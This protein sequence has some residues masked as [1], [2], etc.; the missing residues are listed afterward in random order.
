MKFH[1]IFMAVLVMGGLFL[2]SPG[3]ADGLDTIANLTKEEKLGITN[4]SGVAILTAWGI[5]SWEYGERN[6]HVKS[7]GWFSQDTPEGGADKL[8][9]FYASYLAAHGISALCEF[10]GYSIHKASQYGALSSFGLMTFMEIG[11]SFSHY[12]FSGEDF[13]MNT[14][15]CYAGYVLYR[16]PELAKKI[17]FRIEYTPDF[18][19][20]DM[21]TD[22]GNMKFLVAVK[23][24]G[25][26]SIHNSYLRFLEYHLGYYTRG[27]SDNNKENRRNIYVGLGINLSKLFSDLSWERTSKVFNYYQFPYAYVQVKT[28]LPR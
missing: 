2:T 4:L 16:Y 7:E 6:P 18:S 22:Y 24:A 12:G 1:Y 20:K 10:W 8:A 26:D 23:M 14:L 25:F 11:D 9:H 17:D 19:A 15:G 13:F 21:S 5:T 28:E 27:Y 3:F